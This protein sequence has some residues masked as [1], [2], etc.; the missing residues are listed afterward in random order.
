LYDELI[1]LD[2]LKASKDQLFDEFDD[3]SW[4][5]HLITHADLSKEMLNDLKN[6][7]DLIF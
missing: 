4:P 2:D 7:L 1:S 5:G 6:R 3:G